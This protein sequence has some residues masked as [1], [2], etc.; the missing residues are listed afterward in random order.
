MVTLLSLAPFLLILFL[1]IATTLWM[2]NKK[3][4]LQWTCEHH[5]LIAQQMLIDGAYDLVRLNPRVE[6]LVSHK[7]QLELEMR[8]AVGPERLA[9]AAQLMIVRGQM[10]LMRSQQKNIILT[11]E[12]RA[13]LELL[14]LKKNIKHQ[15]DKIASDWHGKKLFHHLKNPNPQMKVEPQF[16]DILLPTYHFAFDYQNRQRIDTNIK[17]WGP[18]PLPIWLKRLLKRD[19][20][21]WRDHCSTQPRKQGGLPWRSYLTKD[22][23]L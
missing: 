3:E 8:L 1:A 5:S 22:K 19:Q 9:I 4:L 7:R 17:I 20:F 6:S 16:K 18:S 11:A 10:L 14:K 12:S 2:L 15:I 23:H 21:Y 13:R